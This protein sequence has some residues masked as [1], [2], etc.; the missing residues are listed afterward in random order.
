MPINPSPHKT[1]LTMGPKAGNLSAHVRQGLVSTSSRKGTNHSNTVRKRFR[2]LKFRKRFLCIQD[3]QE[4]LL[5]VHPNSTLSDF[6]FPSALGT[7]FISW[8]TGQGW[9]IVSFGRMWEYTHVEYI[10]YDTANQHLAGDLQGTTKNL[11]EDHLESSLSSLWLATEHHENTSLY[12]PF[13]L[14][15]YDLQ[16]LL[17]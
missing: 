17:K 10:C 7:F 4:C 8:R 1:E 16:R 13:F 14:L 6:S 11:T 9:S 12:R 5:S 15:Q 2:N 3:S